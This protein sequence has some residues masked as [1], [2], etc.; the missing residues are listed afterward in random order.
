MYQPRGA[1]GESWEDPPPEKKNRKPGES[2]GGLPLSERGGLILDAAAL[3]S[4]NDVPF[5]VLD[6]IARVP[7]GERTFFDARQPLGLGVAGNTM[8]GMHYISSPTDSLW[9]T[10]GFSFG[11][12]LAPRNIDELIIARAGW[13]AHEWLP[14][15]VPLKTDLGLEWHNGEIALRAELDPSLSISIEEDDDPQF[16]L[17]HA[18]E[19]QYGHAVGGGIRLQGVWLA[20]LEGDENYQMAM[21]PFFTV[22][23]KLLFARAAL[24]LPLTEGLGPPFE[25]YW[26][27]KLATGIRLD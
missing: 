17:Q 2:E 5:T 3:K 10:I 21:E 8:I 1:Y 20:S 24:V 13:D 11:F 26:G 4:E 23:H 27:V 14:Q 22:E 16:F 18:F 7:V 12:P 6:I 19:L 15:Y 25:E 9:L